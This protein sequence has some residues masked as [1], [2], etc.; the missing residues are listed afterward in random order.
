MARRGRPG[1]ADPEGGSEQG[2]SSRD[3]FL[4]FKHLPVCSSLASP[5]FTFY[6][7]APGL[8]RDSGSVRIRV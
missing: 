4:H 2:S 7:R 1:G 8:C 6:L 3:C 5:I